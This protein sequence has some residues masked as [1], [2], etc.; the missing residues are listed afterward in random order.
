LTAVLVRLIE[1]S[2]GPQQRLFT[3]VVVHMFKCSVIVSGGQGE[4]W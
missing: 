4:G 1:E 3:I 2:G